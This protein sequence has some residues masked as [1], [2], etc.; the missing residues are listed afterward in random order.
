MNISE[1][2]IKGVF[3]ITLTSINDE[4][5]FFMR[6]YDQKIFEYFNIDRKWVQENHSRSEKKG[7]IRGLHFQYPQFAEAKLIRCIRGAILD[8]YVDLR[9]NSPTFGKWESLEMTE[10]NRKMLFLPRGFAHGFCTLSEISEVTYKAD[11][12]YSK[13]HESGILWKDPDLKISWPTDNP[14]LSE[15]DHRQPTLK[16][17]VS[18]QT[19]IEEE[20]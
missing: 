5:G 12:Y 2:K 3:E 13:D 7:I 9:K 4:R 14:I 6:T 16:E 11:N 17:F 18:K 10:Q 1:K 15:R 20:V 8:V 19:V